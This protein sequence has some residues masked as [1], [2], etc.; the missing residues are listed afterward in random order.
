MPFTSA[1][2]GFTLIGAVL[3]PAAEA[4]PNPPSTVSVAAQ[5]ADGPGEVHANYTRRFTV[6]NLSSK[7]LELFNIHGVQGEDSHPRFGTVVLP[8]QSMAFEVTW[9]FLQFHDNRAFFN[10]FDANGAHLGTAT[11]DMAVDGEMIGPIPRSAGTIPGGSALADGYQITYLD[12][13]GT[14]IDLPNTNP[15]AQGAALSS[16]CASSAVRCAFTAT[17]TPEQIMGP[18]HVVGKPVNNLTS[19]KQSTTIGDVDVVEMSTSVEISAAATVSVL[20]AVELTVTGTYGQSW[21][22]SH[23]FSQFVDIT[24]APHSRAWLEAEEPVIR[25]TGDFTITAGNTTWTIRGVQFLTPDTDVQRNGELWIREQML[26]A[27]GDGT[28]QMTTRKIGDPAPTAL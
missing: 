23:E 6:S 11:A 28:G 8:G 4:T 10:V 17:R 9:N 27:N 19:R 15:V 16:L 7:K 1:L 26:S 18:R 5:A 20:D 2:V 22:V 21:A 25:T 24:M 12:A 13:P 14:T 3:A